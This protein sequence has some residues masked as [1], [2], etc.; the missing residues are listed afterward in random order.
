MKKMNQDEIVASL[1]RLKLKTLAE[2]KSR[3]T[4]GELKKLIG[5]LS[6]MNIEVARGEFS[7]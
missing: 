6:D 2:L 7:V 5:T 1:I 3:D 4:N